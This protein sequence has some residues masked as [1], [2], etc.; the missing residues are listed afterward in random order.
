MNA[1]LIALSRTTLALLELC[2][3]GIG[4]PVLAAVKLVV[5]VS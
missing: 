5:T 1:V 4:I 2:A 3:K